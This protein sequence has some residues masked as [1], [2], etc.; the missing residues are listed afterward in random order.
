MFLS[1]T[2]DSG[3]I[4]GHI[5]SQ[6]LACD[7]MLYYLALPNAGRSGFPLQDLLRINLA[8][9][10]KLQWAQAVSQSPSPVP[11]FRKGV[12]A[13]KKFRLLAKIPKPRHT[14]SCCFHCSRVRSQT[15]CTFWWR[16]EI[17]ILSLIVH[18]K[19]LPR[20]DMYP[21]LTVF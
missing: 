19:H 3:K 18:G 8:T 13:S 7:K 16:G 1:S 10:M 5:K 21:S 15:H 9:K 4:R 6:I 11:E 17:C 12:S 20:F 2:E 14:L